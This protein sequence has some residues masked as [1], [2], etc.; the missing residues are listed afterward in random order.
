MEEANDW[1]GGVGVIKGDFRWFIQL[2]HMNLYPVS[3]AVKT[4]TGKYRVL[5]WYEKQSTMGAE[6]KEPFNPIV[7]ITLE[8]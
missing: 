7:E 5:T 2:R 6:R 4:K 8:K 1:K 3:D